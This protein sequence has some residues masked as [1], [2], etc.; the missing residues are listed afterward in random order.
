MKLA[1]A[2]AKRV[3]EL[4]SERKMTQYELSKRG[5]IPRSTLCVLTRAKY[6]T[7]KLDTVYQ[8]AATLGI[9]LEEF[10]NSRLFNDLED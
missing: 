3:E 1:E 9:S 10:F 2:V 4:L 6:S 5:G 8:I 7:V